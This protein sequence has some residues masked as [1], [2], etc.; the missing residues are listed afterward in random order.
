[1]SN[2]RTKY[3]ILVIDDDKAVASMVGQMLRRMGYYSI[4]CNRP[5]DALALFSRVSE[6]FDAVIVDEM[7]PDI[8]GTQLAAQ[9][10]RV[11]DDISII[12]MTGRGDMITLGQV[13]ESGVRATLIKPVLRE[14][15]RIVLGRL[16]T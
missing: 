2:G 11:R 9:L 14:R 3:R 4:V 1:M 8:R 16:F 15:L 5:L 7:M 10:L 12:L 6:R 13:R